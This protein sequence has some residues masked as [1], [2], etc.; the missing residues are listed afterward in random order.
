MSNADKTLAVV[1]RERV[2]QYGIKYARVEELIATILGGGIPDETIN[3]LKKEDMKNLSAMTEEELGK[4][5]GIGKNKAA[6]LA[7]AFEL[8]RRFASALPEKG[9]LITRPVDVFDFMAAEMSNLDREEFRALLLNSK[10]RLMTVEIVSIGSLSA[11]ITHPRETY[12]SA[13]KR[14]ASTII[15]VHNHP[16]GDPTP[17]KEDI[18]ITQRFNEAGKIIGINLIDHIIIGGMNYVSLKEKGII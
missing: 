18:E 8:S 2:M 11:T 6:V 12:K 14:S 3:T 16:S 17:S 13:I 1:A 15:L 10:H 4:L 7:A 5:P 9:Y